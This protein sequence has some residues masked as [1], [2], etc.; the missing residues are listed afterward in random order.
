MLGAMGDS[1][2][3][4]T[5]IGGNLGVPA[6]QLLTENADLY[7]LELSSFQLERT[8]VLNASF[9]TVLNVSADHMDR[10]SNINQYAKEKN[11]VFSGNGVMVLNSDDPIVNDMLEPDRKTTFFSVHKK[12]GFHLELAENEMWLMDEGSA[13]DPPI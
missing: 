2:N 1:C 6:L 4:K 11:K 12:N 7:V 13:I 10:H 8:S 3:V 9:A 5:A